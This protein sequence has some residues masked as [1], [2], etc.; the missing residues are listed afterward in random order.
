MLAIVSS[1][2]EIYDKAAKLQFLYT[3]LRESSFIIVEELLACGK[4]MHAEL[5]RI[6]DDGVDV[7]PEPIERFEHIQNEMAVAMDMVQKMGG[8]P[9]F[10][11]DDEE[12]GEDYEENDED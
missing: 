5:N 10:K 8:K 2:K 1:F 11:V 12:D 6:E 3:E 9:G 7:D 4:I